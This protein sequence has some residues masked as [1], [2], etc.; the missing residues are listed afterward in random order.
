MQ[1]NEKEMIKKSRFI[2][3]A[4]H[5]FSNDFGELVHAISQCGIYSV[6][7]IDLETLLNVFQE[8]KWN[9][10]LKRI[11]GHAH[12]CHSIFTDIMKKVSTMDIEASFIGL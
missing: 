4:Y 11:I 6:F 8:S 10:T 3:V 12:I 9:S 7:G 5:S 1:F 2:A